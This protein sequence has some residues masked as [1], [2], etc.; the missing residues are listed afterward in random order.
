M[1]DLID[2]RAELPDAPATIPMFAASTAARLGD[3]DG[4]GE[5]AFVKRARQAIRTFGVPGEPTDEGERLVVRDGPRTLQVYRASDSVWWV[6]FDRAYG[7]APDASSELPSEGDALLR[8]R[9][10]LERARLDMRDAAEATTAPVRVAVQ[11]GDAEPRGLDVAL[12]VNLAFS[13]AGRPVFGPGAKAKVTFAGGGEV[14]QVL[15]F[16]RRPARARA[17]PLIPADEAFARFARDPAFYR[18]RKTDAAVEVRDVQLGYYAL[19]PGDFQRLYVPVYAVDA[20]VRT[21]EL[22]A[23]D[24]RRHVVAVDVSP[25]QAKAL[26]AVADPSACRLF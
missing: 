18:L 23:Y 1:R 19:P 16:W 6:D 24:F 8:A 13:L 12:D 4:K 2:M 20:T 10:E 3:R 21:R 5:A 14:A 15:Y 25:G 7:D 26:D 22:P 11:E 9:A 17:M